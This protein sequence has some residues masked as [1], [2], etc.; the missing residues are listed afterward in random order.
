MYLFHRPI[1]TVLKSLY[2]PASGTGQ[3]FY[4]TCFCLV[5]VILTWSKRK[6]TFANHLTREGE[7]R[8]RDHE[9][10]EIFEKAGYKVIKRIA[11]IHQST[12][13]IASSL[14]LAD[15]YSSM[16]SEQLAVLSSLYVLAP[17]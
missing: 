12:Q 11:Q 3:I 6:H 5:L 16:S 14:P 8:L 2:F 10:P 15:P 4:L 9:Y 1:Y 13:A 7:N 17:K